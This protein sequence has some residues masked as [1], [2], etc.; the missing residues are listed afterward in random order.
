[1]A[2][3]ESYDLEKGKTIKIMIVICD[4]K[5]EAIW[6]DGRILDIEEGNKQKTITY[7][8]TIQKA[9]Q[10]AQRTIKKIDKKEKKNGWK[11]E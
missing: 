5:N 8:K 9:I 3:I 10:T 11:I 2:H 4:V 7:I 1:M 6:R